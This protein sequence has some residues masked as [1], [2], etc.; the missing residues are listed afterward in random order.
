MVEGL[1][2]V[3]ETV[4]SVLIE[5]APNGN[6]STLNNTDM[7]CTN[8]ASTPILCK[9]HNRRFVSSISLS[10]TIVFTVTYTF[11]EY[12]WANWHNFSISSI[13]LPAATRAPKRLA[14]I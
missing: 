6:S 8:T 7:S 12:E 2:L 1:R 10:K 14:P 13:E 3:F 4:L 5:F 9:S 11:A